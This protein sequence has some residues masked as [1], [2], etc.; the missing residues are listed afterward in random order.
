MHSICFL[1][2]WELKQL[3]SLCSF[4]TYFF[5]LKSFLFFIV[6]ELFI[7]LFIYLYSL[8]HSFIYLFIYFIHLFFFLR[9]S[10]HQ[11]SLSAD[12]V[13]ARQETEFGLRCLDL[14][15]RD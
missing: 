8:I 6:I 7:Y 4:K 9:G 15:S 13:A 2:P 11:I 1:P 5:F 14:S 3:Y 10:G 12:A